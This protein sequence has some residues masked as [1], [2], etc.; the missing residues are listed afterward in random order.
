MVV[1]GAMAM[2]LKVKEIAQRVGIEN[3]KQL[4][5]VTGLSVTSCYQLWNGTAKAI[6]FESLNTL[7]NVLQAGPALLLDYTPDVEPQ[8]E[9]G[10]AESEQGKAP[11]GSSARS[12]RK[13]ARRAAPAI[14]G[15]L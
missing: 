13:Q 15:T 14:A 7:C 9:R 10:P 6:S 12:T 8:G 4:A 2:R 5:K 3:A 1:C 11:R